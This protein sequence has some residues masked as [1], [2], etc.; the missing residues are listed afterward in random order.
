MKNWDELLIEID[1]NISE[2]ELYVRERLKIRKR[3]NA[4]ADASST[5][6]V[7]SEMKRL[8]DI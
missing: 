4:F 6:R 7:F 5:D 2:P 8:L 3:F 1:R